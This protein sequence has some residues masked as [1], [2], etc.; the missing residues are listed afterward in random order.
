MLTT[1]HRLLRPFP[2]GG[3]RSCCSPRSLDCL[4][5]AGVDPRHVENVQF[6]LE[7]GSEL[8]ILPRVDDDVGAG[9]KHQQHVREDTNVGRPR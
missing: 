3:P 1:Q 9:V 6:S 2:L 8:F 5:V 7:K 4:H